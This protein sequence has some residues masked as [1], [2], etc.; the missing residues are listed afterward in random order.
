MAD[1]NSDDSNPPLTFVACVSDEEIL[2]ANLLASACLKPGSAHEVI[3]IKN[4]Q[5]A[6]DGLNRGIARARHELVVCLHQDVRLP[7]G[8]DQRL[9]QQLRQPRANGDQS[10]SRGSMA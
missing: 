3:L 6:A 7:H 5:N 1:P 10:E 8:W 2:H 4:C 9:V